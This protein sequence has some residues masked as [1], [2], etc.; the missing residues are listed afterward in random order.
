MRSK[1]YNNLS[2]R[3]NL[4]LNEKYIIICHPENATFNTN[5]NNNST[6]NNNNNNKNNNNNNKWFISLKKYLQLFLK[7]IINSSS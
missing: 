5:N 1:T 3:C 2:K 6:N 7:L 4:C